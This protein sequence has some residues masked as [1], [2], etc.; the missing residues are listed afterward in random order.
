MYILQHQRVHQ[1]SSCVITGCVSVNPGRVMAL[2]IVLVVLMKTKHS[3]TPAP[4][5]SS[6]QMAGVQTCKMCVTELITV[7][8]IAT[9]IESVL[10]SELRSMCQW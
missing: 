7:E 8:I 3:V 2:K 4:S 5:G 6:A 9:K 1:M 10:V